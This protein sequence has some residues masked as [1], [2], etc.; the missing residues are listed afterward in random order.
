MALASVLCWT[1]KSSERTRSYIARW[2]ATPTIEIQVV[3]NGI[4]WFRIRILPIREIAGRRIFE[5][6]EPIVLVLVLVLEEAA[7]VPAIAL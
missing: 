5:R 1:T 2:A 3:P 4:R 7:T 6:A